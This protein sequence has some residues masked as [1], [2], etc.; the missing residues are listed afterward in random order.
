MEKTRICT[1]TLCGKS[2]NYNHTC[3]AST[4]ICASCLVNRWRHKLKRNMIEYSGGKCQ[5]CGYARCVK[6]LAFHHVNPDEKDFN[7]S[8]NHCRRWKRLVKEL[9]KCVLLCMN[10]HNEVHAGMY[11]QEQL[12]ALK[13][14]AQA[15][16]PL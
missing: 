4:K 11:T 2:Y 8:G 3:G 6:A 14:G 10:C 5:I 16:A 1:C 15:R 12:D 13:R 9:D 7:I